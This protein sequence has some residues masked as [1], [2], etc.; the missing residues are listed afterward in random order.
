MLIKTECIRGRTF[1][2]RAEANIALFEYTDGFCD[3]RRIQERLGF[4][5]PIEFEEKHCA[6]QATAEPT[7][8]NTPP[9]QPLLTS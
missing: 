9:H 4:L 8:L 3:S 1:T 5:S 6:E 2:A 7:N